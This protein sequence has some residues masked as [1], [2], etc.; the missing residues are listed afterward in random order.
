MCKHTCSQRPELRFMNLCAASFRWCASRTDSLR[1]AVPTTSSSSTLTTTVRAVFWACVWF[2]AGITC[3][4]SA[5]VYRLK[6]TMP[7]CQAVAGCRRAGRGTT[8]STCQT[9]ASRPTC[10]SRWF[11]PEE[12]ALSDL[13]FSRRLLLVLLAG[14]D[15]SIIL[16]VYYHIVC[17]H[18]L[19]NQDVK[20]HD[21]TYSNKWMLYSLH[22]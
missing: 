21:S 7:V 14:V 2:E 20:F 11:A 9:A 3:C 13:L 4:Q 16:S 1:C 18:D 15:V 10:R 6:R 19:S 12:H 5:C 8:W 22:K 17:D